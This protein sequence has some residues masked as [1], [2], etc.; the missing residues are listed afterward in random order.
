MRI[1][2]T[3]FL[4]WVSSVCTAAMYVMIKSTSEFSKCMKQ[5]KENRD[6][7]EVKSR[8]IKR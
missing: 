6:I 5:E 4:I 1:L 8:Q 3:A 7:C 2:I